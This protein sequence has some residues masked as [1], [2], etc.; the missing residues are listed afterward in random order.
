[1]LTKSLFKIALECPTKLYYEIN[2]YSSKKTDDDFLTALANGGFQVGELAKCYYPKGKTLKGKTQNELVK[3]TK[4]LLKK[5]NVVIFEAAFKTKDLYVQVDILEKKK[6][7]LKIIEVKSKSGNDNVDFRNKKNSS[8]SADW[9]K[10]LYDVAFQKY[11]IVKDTKEKYTIE[12]YLMLGN[13]DSKTSVDNLNQ[14]FRIKNVKGKAE[15]KRIGDCSLAAI[16]E[17]ILKCHDVS[18]LVEEIL[19]DEHKKDF[20]KDTFDK[21]VIELSQNIKKNTKILNPVGKKCKVCEFNTGERNSGFMECWKEV[22]NSHKTEKEENIVYNVYG[23]GNA[24]ARIEDKKY[25]MSKLIKKDFN[26]PQKNEELTTS[27]RQYLQ[28]DSI[29][30]KSTKKFI[31]KVGLKSEFKKWKFPFHLID[32]E[33]SSPAIPF[34][35]DKRPYQR[36]AFQFSHHTI[37]D[38]WNIKHEGEFLETN[39]NAYPNL[40]FLRE[41]KNQLEKDA[42]TVFMYHFYERTVLNDLKKVLIESSEKD[43]DDKKD[44]IDWIDTLIC[45]NREMVDLLEVLKNNY[46]DPRMKGSNSLKVVLPAILNSS[47]YL[48]KRYQKPIYGTNK[49][50]SK[51]FKDHTWIKVDGNG[52]VQDPY[53]LLEDFKYDIDED[54]RIFKSNN[55]KNGGAAMIAYNQMQYEEM[56]D[57]ERARL[58]K[59]LKEY[60]ELDTFAMVLLL[61]FWNDEI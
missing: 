6:S 27:N 11:V 34:M 29:L 56:T 24:Q 54:D 44:L 18:V 45:G 2:K 1:M 15:V 36:I 33:T 30:K 3:E 23:Y 46:Y 58:E 43:V 40:N 41:L 25:F 39:P 51:N 60:C 12:S 26:V 9:I 57:T 20:Y 53:S 35:K 55:I 13:K 4:E 47:N 14:K 37:D 52:E 21:F 31:N 42:G 32:F 38:N 61:V 19:N 5:N 17:K 10:Y 7:T 22:F 8:I 50:E 48:K 28:V 59:A 49:I 16:G